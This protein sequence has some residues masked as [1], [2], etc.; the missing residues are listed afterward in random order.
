MKCDDCGKINAEYRCPECNAHFCQ[1]CA[2]GMEG[3]C[4][5]CAPSLVEI[6][7]KRK[8]RKKNEHRRSKN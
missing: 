8:V 6:K 2:D 3:A 1:D 5:Y 4:S 7:K